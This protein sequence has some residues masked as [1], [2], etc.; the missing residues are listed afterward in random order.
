MKLVVIGGVAGGASVAARARRL[1]EA[2]EIVVLERSNYVSFA[3]C[4]LPYHIGGT[5]A[6][7]ERLLL[8]TPQSLRDS[9]NLDVRTGHE[10]IAIDRAA[11]TVRVRELATGREYTESYDKLALCP[12]ATPLRP[13]LPGLDHPAVRVLRNIEDMDDI[14]RR[15]D[16][17]AKSAV[18]IGAGYIG[19]EMAEN[20]RDRGIAVD[21]VELEPQVMPPLD[22]EM[23][24]AIEEHLREHGVRLH[25][26]TAAAAVRDAGGRAAVE[27]RNGRTIEADLVM[28]SAGV[29]PETTLARAAG[30]EIGP[31]GGIRVDAHLRTSDPDIYAA[32]DAVEVAHTVLPGEWLIPLAGP[33]NRQARVAAD[34]ICGRDSTYESTQGTAIV[35]V[36]ELTAGATGASEKQLTRANLPYRKI[37]IHPSDHAGYYPGAAP[38]HI[39]LLFAPDNGRILGAQVC[40]FD[41]VDKRLDV[42]ATALRA[43]LTVFDLEKLE[44]AYA[45]PY[46]SAKDPVNMA[47]FVAANVLRGDLKLW[48]A[49]EW[50]KSVESAFIVDVRS[51]AEYG[52]WHLPGA[53]NIPLGA[54]RARLGQ[55]PKDRPIRLYCKVGFRSYLA[56]RLLKQRGFEDVATLAGGTTTFRAWHREVETPETDGPATE[57][58]AEEAA[59][60]LVAATAAAPGTGRI[61]EVDCAGL[62]CP[63]PILRLKQE[64]EKLTPGDTLLM[65][66]SDPGFAAD[67]KA[68][69]AG[70]GHTLVEVAR[71]NGLL[72][73]R[74]RKERPSAVPTTSATTAA[75]PP[76]RKTFVVFS[77]DLDRVLA[78]FVIANGTLAMGG[79]VSMFFTFWGLNALRKPAPPP[80]K[81]DFISRMFGAMLPRGA[82]RLKLSQMHMLGAGTAMMRGLMRKKNVPSLPEMIETARRGGAKLIACTMSMEVMGLRP[83]EL[84]DG[85]EFGGVGAF[86]GD[87]DRSRATIFI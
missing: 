32:G 74:I 62:Q 37:Y 75:A 30:L 31:R 70:T 48:Y 28:L 12:G 71:R 43:G 7:R 86:L 73:A 19:V 47:G 46:G 79:E 25:L 56:Y 58:Y 15:V 69:C 8:Q 24:A 36:F 85:I 29:R 23:A 83:E 10:A 34:N 38:M 40:G 44:L 51:P 63:G 76:H 14:K 9:L 54:L 27:L 68:W 77:G 66:V 2:A 35:K 60:T 87:A 6:E 13:P 16:A 41:G 5:I 57:F 20:L 52:V 49:E 45:P 65:R 81:K 84:L 21:L 80:V 17:G 53:V 55:L 3:N 42:F 82:A 61:V 22:R 33:A 64:M 59:T 78:A 67:V 1:D 4:G 50:P 11:K 72:E 26:G 18:I 39:K